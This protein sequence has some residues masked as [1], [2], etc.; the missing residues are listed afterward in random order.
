MSYTSL[1]YHIVFST[2]DQSPLI[3][4]EYMPRLIQYLGGIVRELDGR[5]ITAHGTPDHIHLAVSLIPKRALADFIRVVKNNTARWI[6]QTFPDLLD[7]AWQEGFAAF[8]VAHSGIKQ[9]ES[10]IQKQT[11]HHK[12][13]SF[14]RELITLLKRH[15][16]DFDEDYILT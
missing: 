15:D 1:K 9:V 11:D 8:T 3:R 10:Y 14:R 12:K 13:M 4:P 6:H 16:I 5:L 2:R 7:F